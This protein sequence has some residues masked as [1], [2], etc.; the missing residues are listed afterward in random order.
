MA[1]GL[2]QLSAVG[3]QDVYLTSSPNHNFFK[4][5]YHRYHNFALEEIKQSSIGEINF[6]KNFTTR[7]ARRGDLVTYLA[8]SFK[9]PALSIP[10]GSTY[11]GWTNNLSMALV[12]SAELLIG[13]NRID[14]LYSIWMDIWDELAVN[15][16]IRDGQS[17]LI[18]KFETVSEVQ[19]NATGITDYYLRL[20]FWFLN[21]PGLAIP[22]VA[23]QYHDIELKI[24]F[25]DFSECV[26]FDG[27]TPPTAVNFI[28]G[29]VYAEYVYLEDKIRSKFA[30]QP[31]AYLITQTQLNGDRQTISTTGASGKS[32]NT[33]LDFNHPVSELNWVL[34]E[35][36]SINNNDWFNYSRRSD[37]SK[38]ID[39]ARLLLDGQPRMDMRDELYFRLVQPVQ[40]HTHSNNKHIYSYSFALDPESNVQPSGSL[41]FSRFDTVKLQLELRASNPETNLYVFAK[42]WNILIIR[43][44][45]AGLAYN[46]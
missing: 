46:N 38:Q 18:G 45:M 4:S 6:G 15:E 12:K 5:V 11:V 29:E 44:G 7:I 34:V 25:R 22:L 26:T 37:T 1:G 30:Q 35:T 31:H 13:G 36:D 21:K 33:L 41:N 16:S 3:K 28:S 19:T 14:K 9:L 24:E 17:R 43:H 10:S 8:L 27:A 32:F 42:N 20:P 23:L 40:F 2:L 39:R